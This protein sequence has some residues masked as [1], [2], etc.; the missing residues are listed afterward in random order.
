MKRLLTFSTF[1]LLFLALALPLSAQTTTGNLT[2]DITDP[3][4]ARLPGVTVKATSPQLGTARETITNEFGTYRLSAL[5]PSTYN[6]TA[7]LTGFKTV[8]RSVTVG[9]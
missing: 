1:A 9:L 6:V 7:E 5:P 3:T 4:G 8:Q 2:G